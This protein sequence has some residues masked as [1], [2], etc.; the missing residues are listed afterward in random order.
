V[1]SVV[2]NTYPPHEW[3][4]EYLAEVYGVECD[5]STFDEQLDA[6]AQKQGWKRSVDEK[7]NR[8]RKQYEDLFL[9]GVSN[10][11]QLLYYGFPAREVRL[12]SPQLACCCLIRRLFA[13][14]LC[15]LL[16]SLF[17]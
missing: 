16:C 9:Q 6:F 13:S 17:T 12:F 14:V 11:L 1:D 15:S 3:L 8:L 7:K 5:F 2:P 4:S 10:L